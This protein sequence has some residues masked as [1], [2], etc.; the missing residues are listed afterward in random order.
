MDGDE[1]M[2]LA[3]SLI[4]ITPDQEKAAYRAIKNVYGAKNIYHLLGDHD[5]LLIHEAECLSSLKKTLNDIKELK[6]VIVMR[7]MV[8]T[9]VEGIKANPL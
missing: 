2:V 7:T 9:P 5:L 6:F 1:R 3:V 4:Q 8:Q